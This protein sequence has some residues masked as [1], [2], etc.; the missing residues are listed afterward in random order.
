[1]HQWSVLQVQIKQQLSERLNMIRNV[2][3]EL[4]P[5]K[6]LFDRS[7]GSE[8]VA[9]ELLSLLGAYQGVRVVVLV[10]VARTA[11]GRNEM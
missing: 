2:R 4:Q 10:K 5:C 1:V 3:D 9:K 6:P 7:I 11:G 8:R